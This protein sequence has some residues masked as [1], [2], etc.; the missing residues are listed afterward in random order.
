MKYCV[1]NVRD[2]VFLETVLV[3]AERLATV[4]SKSERR[5]PHRLSWTRTEISAYC[6]TE[7]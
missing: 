4:N 6:E 7:S 2:S 1:G 5:W 3:E